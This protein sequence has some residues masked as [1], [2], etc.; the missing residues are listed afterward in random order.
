MDDKQK[1]ENG[2]VILTHGRSIM[3]LVAA[4]S[5]GQKGVEVIGCDSIDLTILSFSKYVE[6][7]FI[8]PDKKKDE[9]AFLRSMIEQIKNYKPDDDRPYILMP[10]FKDNKFFARHRD[11]FEPHIKLA[12]PDFDALCALHPKDNFARTVQ[13]LDVSA[14]QTWLPENKE[15][16]EELSDEFDFPCIIKPYDQS[17]G[18][19]IHKIDTK[20]QLLKYWDEN[21]KKF[22]QKSLIQSAVEGDE[23]CYSAIFENGDLKAGMAYKNLYCFPPESGSGILRETIP[24]EKFA[25]IAADLMKPLE[26][27]G[28]AEFDF[29]WDGDDNTTPVLIEVNTRFWG[30]LFQ[31]VE[32]GIDFPWLLYCL[33]TQGHIETSESSAIGTKT[34]M[35]YIWLVSALSDA[36][37]NDE[38]FEKIEK[39][40]KLALEKIKN[41]SVLQGMKDYGSYLFAYMGESLNLGKKAKKFEQS[42][43]IGRAAKNELLDSDDPYVALGILFVFGSLYRQ[44]HLPRELKF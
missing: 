7:F 20:A 32:S 35:P 16:L 29:L 18:R 13:E 6:D 2:R 22:G 25:R 26:W 15:E 37:K 11:K 4:Q 5:L 41:G 31:S 12:C 10:M 21:I 42:L 28:V 40:G 38:E 14:P 43:K 3:A 27:N 39:Q 24:H 30:G 23:Y 17:S 8:H 1:L 19:G 9:D 36:I 44:G 33:T 34:K